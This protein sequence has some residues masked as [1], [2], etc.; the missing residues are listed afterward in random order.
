M[1]TAFFEVVEHLAA[2]MSRK[3]GYM[4]KQ[5]INW[6]IYAPVLVKEILDR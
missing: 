5:T 3:K 1:L 4:L 2:Y 6:V